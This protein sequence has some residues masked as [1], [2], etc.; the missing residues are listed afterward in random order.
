MI[1]QPVCSF[2]Y[3]FIRVEKVGT[4]IAVSQQPCLHIYMRP[5]NSEFSS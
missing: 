5:L 3:L 2:V 4:Y 1:Y